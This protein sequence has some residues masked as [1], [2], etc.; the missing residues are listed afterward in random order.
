[1]LHRSVVMGEHQLKNIMVSAMANLI[2]PGTKVECAVKIDEV[3]EEIDV[4][5]AVIYDSFEDEIIMSQTTPELLSPFAGKRIAVT[6]IE[7]KDNVRKGLSGKVNKIIKDYKLSSSQTVPAIV[8]TELSDLKEYNIRLL[9]RVRPPEESD[10]KLSTSDN[11]MLEIVDISV[12]GVKFCHSQS[13]KLKV[14][15]EIKLCL[16]LHDE[17]HEVSARVVRKEEGQHTRKV[18]YVAVQFLGLSKHSE[19]ELAKTVRE[20]ERNIRFKKMLT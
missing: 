11:E 17:P 20:I 9:Y 5:Q 1:M 13:W 18:E 4:R 14:N 10:I 6:Y 7:G 2:R 19:D 3:N 16:K 15:Q 8:L 12:S